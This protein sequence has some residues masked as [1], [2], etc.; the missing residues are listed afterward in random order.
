MIGKTNGGGGRDRFRS[1]I[2]GGTT[3]PARP[4]EG[5]F[6]IYTGTAI[7]GTELNGFMSGF[8]TWTMP[9]GFV[10]IG[11]GG[12]YNESSWVS[13]INVRN[14]VHNFCPCCCYQVEGGKWYRKDAKVYR[15][16]AWLQFSTW[17]APWDGTLWGPNNQY[18]DH[19]GGWGYA[20][21]NENVPYFG[22]FIRWSC[23][24]TTIF[25]YTNWAV[26]VT[27]FSRLRYD[28]Q[29][30]G[31]TSF[32]L[33]NKTGWLD[34]SNWVARVTGDGTVYNGS[35]DISGV[36]GSFYITAYA[37]SE[38]GSGALFNKIWLE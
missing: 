33:S 28:G 1:K 10:Y 34:G 7:S 4:Q 21:S 32:G 31:E 13:L 18:T 23:D 2:Y 15:N 11:S 24:N 9:E 14:G 29:M 36:S 19:T 35:V 6:W 30:W 26:D 22:E 17:A 8:P 5:D 20:S 25:L 27:K 3:A 38:G 16:G 37:S 12:A